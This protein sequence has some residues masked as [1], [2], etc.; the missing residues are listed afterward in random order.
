MVEK[1]KKTEPVFDMKNETSIPY[2]YGPKRDWNTCTT[3]NKKNKNNKNNKKKQTVPNS[4]SSSMTD[5]KKVP[6]VK[7]EWARPG[8]A[9]CHSG[10]KTE[11]KLF[12]LD[13]A[14]ARNLRNERPK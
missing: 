7:R 5:L 12:Q 2:E 13:L 11:P 10:P 9:S 6:E 4:E 3:T 8:S 14:R 1:L